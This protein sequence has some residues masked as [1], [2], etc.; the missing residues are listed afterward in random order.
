ML[1]RIEQRKSDLVR[2]GIALVNKAQKLSAQA[3]KEIA[4]ETA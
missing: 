4:H 2:Q 1:W 3:R